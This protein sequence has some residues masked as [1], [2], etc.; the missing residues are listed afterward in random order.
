MPELSIIMPSTVP[1]AQPRPAARWPGVFGRPGGGGRT[2]LTW[3]AEAGGLTRRPRPN[4]AAHGLAIDGP[5]PLPG[6]YPPRSTGFRYWAIAEALARAA[7]LWRAAIGPGFA[8]RS[9][10]RLHVELGGPGAQGIYDR[11]AIR[12][13]ASATPETAWRT[14]GLAVLDTLR[15]DLWD[16]AT[17]EA[18]ALHTGFAEATVQLAVLALPDQHVHALARTTRPGFPAAFA[19]I[20]GALDAVGGTQAAHSAARLLVIAAH[21]VPA[22]P[23]LLSQF[24]AELAVATAVQEGPALAATL[25]DLFA[26]HGLLART[27]ALDRYDPHEAEDGSEIPPDRHPLPWV[28]VDAPGLALPLLLCPASQQPRLFA[29]APA[30]DGSARDAPAP[31][32]EA[33]R[34]A[35]ALT[36]VG[37]VEQPRIGRAQR[38]APGTNPL[39]THLLVDD[40]R[41]LR[42]VRQR[43]V[44]G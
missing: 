14:L 34:H 22:A 16:I 29:A 4:L 1:L 7:G 44:V 37:L 8:W 43:M 17:P 11:A 38:S 21:R 25:R 19:A 5:M 13:G 12:L 31:L 40:G 15:P 33:R 28:A 39:A 2:V 6:E 41:T 9:D 20:I 32:A 3:S 36:R 35:D 27:P 10:G 24:A 18:D 23:N 30:A 26:T 42:L